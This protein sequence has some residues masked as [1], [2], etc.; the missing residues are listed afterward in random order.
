VDVALY[1]TSLRRTYYRF[2]KSSC[3]SS[4]MPTVEDYDSVLCF[5]AV[6]SK[7]FSEVCSL[8]SPRAVDQVNFISAESH[9][10]FANLLCRELNMK[11]VLV[12][13]DF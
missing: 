10:L 1:T 2:N 12:T 7:F 4:Y 11:K 9:V 13:S 5:S 3:I 8:A 6:D